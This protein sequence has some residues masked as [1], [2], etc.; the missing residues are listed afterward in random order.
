MNRNIIVY[1]GILLSISYISTQIVLNFIKLSNIPP[2]PLW[3]IGIFTSLCLT[4]ATLYRTTPLG[5]STHDVTVHPWKRIVPFKLRVFGVYILYFCGLIPSLL[6]F[7]VEEYI[8][9]IF[10]TGIP[11]GFLDIMF[12]YDLIN[13]DIQNMT[14]VYSRSATYAILRSVTTILVDH[15]LMS[16]ALSKA[17]PLIVSSTETLFMFLLKTTAYRFSTKSLTF[18]SYAIIKATIFTVLPL[19][20]GDLIAYMEK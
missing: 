9:A 5:T 12:Q 14:F 16:E 4:V 3:T 8:V 11:L 2:F 7:T 1:I 13:Y 18:A 17:I 6:F 19:I 15:D 20:E 10:V